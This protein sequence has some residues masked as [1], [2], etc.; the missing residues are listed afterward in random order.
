[1]VYVTERPACAA[2]H[3]R[4]APG[5][6]PPLA[7]AIRSIAVQPQPPMEWAEWYPVQLPGPTQTQKVS[8]AHRIRTTRVPTTRVPRARVPRA[9]TGIA[10][11]AIAL[12]LLAGCDRRTKPFVPIEQE[13]PKLAK[14]TVPGLEAPSA[15][16]VMPP[17]R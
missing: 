5:L 1:M 17:P 14:V 6:S 13:P 3:V 16:P 2:P 15:A 9:G 8:M 7:L 11:G 4:G 10:L 12:A